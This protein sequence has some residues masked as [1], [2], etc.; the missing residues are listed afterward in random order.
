MK[1]VLMILT[2]VGLA[3]PLTAKEVEPSIKMLDW[4]IGEWSYADRQVK[5]EY[6]DQ[7]T[8]HC[9]YTLK[10][11]YIVCESV[12]V[13]NAGKERVYLFYL[14]Y[15]KR[16]ARFEMVALFSDYQSKNLYV[17]E[18]SKGGYV[19]DLKNHEWNQQGLKQL[20]DAQISYDGQGVWEW[21]IRYGEVDPE[22]NE[23]P[24][25]FIDTAI[26]Q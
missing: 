7:G 23:V 22:T 3:S 10:E 15:N 2:V 9:R 6:T 25:S 12:G 24:V 13:T 17:M 11:Q 4:M 5:G 26:R 14:N 19:I 20:S 18:V 21:Q 16:H 8:R 1:T